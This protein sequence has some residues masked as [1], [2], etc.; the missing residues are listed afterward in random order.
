MVISG[1]YTPEDN[2]R[3]SRILI[4]VIVTGA[5]F[6]TGI[7]VISNLNYALDSS[8]PEKSREA[9]IIE[10]T[11][12]HHS[13]GDDEFYITVN[14][15]GSELKLNVYE[16]EYEYLEEGDTVLVEQYPGAFGDAYYALAYEET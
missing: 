5:V 14:A 11:S 7:F 9:G 16:D 8:L 3:S 1:L 15:G 12:Y 4:P 13:K 10:K 6:L 2:S